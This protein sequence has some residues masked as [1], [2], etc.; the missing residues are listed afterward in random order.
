ME[1][2][3]NSLHVE[4]CGVIEEGVLG[5][6]KNSEVMHNFESCSDGSK[7]A[8]LSSSTTATGTYLVDV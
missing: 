4:G 1:G 5:K 3:R 2:Q 8:L 6:L 7:N